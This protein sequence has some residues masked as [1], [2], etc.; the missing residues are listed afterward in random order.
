MNQSQRDLPAK[1]TLPGASLA[2]GAAGGGPATTR[3]TGPASKPS[4]AAQAQGEDTSLT[5]FGAL[6]KQPTSPCLKYFKKKNI[7]RMTPRRY[8]DGVS[9]R[10]LVAKE[11][12]LPKRQKLPVLLLNLDGALGYWDEAKTYVFKERGLGQLIALAHNFRIV[13]YSAEPKGLVKRLGRA[14]AEYSRP[15]CF[16]ALYQILGRP[17]QPRV[18]VSH[19]LLDFSDEEEE[20]LDLFA[21]SSVVMVTVDK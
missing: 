7:S 8:R 4:G 20:D 15:F 14:L 21:C 13:G 11:T 10:I 9:T 17:H 16:D 18:N 2:G 5:A 1:P 6:Q 12:F 19:V 3:A